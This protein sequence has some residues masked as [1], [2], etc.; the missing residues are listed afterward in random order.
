MT[1]AVSYVIVFALSLWAASYFAQPPAPLSAEVER[2]VFSATR[3]MLDVETIAVRPHP[4]GSPDILRVRSYI[5]ARLTGLN[6]DVAPDAGQK[7]TY[8]PTRV[9]Q[10]AIVANVHNV[11]ATLKGTSPDLPAILLMSHY[12]T[13]ANSP[14]APDD[15]A[16]V[17]A[18]LEIASNL[19]A[20][21][22]LKRDVIFL[23]TEGEE[24]GLLGARAFFNQNP[25]ARRVGLVINLESRGG[26]GRAFMFETSDKAGG[27]I[28]AYGKAVRDPAANSLSAFIYRVMPNGTDL[29]MAF[30]ANIPGLNFAF[31]G[32]EFAYHTSSAT[33]AN[34]NSG[35]VQH[36]GDQVLALTAAL[37]NADDLRASEPDLVY[38]DVFGHG[39][40]S[41]S[42]ATGWALIALLAVI[43]GFATWKA[44]ADRLV[45]G[46]SIAIGAGFFLLLV[47]VEGVVFF[48]AGRGLV[49]AFDIQAKYTMIARY[50]F[51]LGGCILLALAIAWGLALAL[52][53]VLTLWG[54][55]LGGLILLFVIALGLQIAAPATTLFFVWPLIPASLAAALIIALA[56]GEPDTG[57]A[58]VI[59]VP[60]SFLSM[61]QIASF[62]SAAFLGLGG[63]LPAILV[64]PTL[65]AA[66]ALYPA[67]EAFV[68]LPRSSILA[69]ALVLVAFVSLGWAKF[70]PA[71]AAHPRLTQAFYLAGP[72]ADQYARVSMLK[73]LDAWSEAALTADGGKPEWST[74]TPGYVLPAWRAEA[75][76]AAVPRP[77]L[78]G[79]AMNLISGKRVTLKIIPAGSPRELRFIMQSDVAVTDLAIDG[80]PLGLTPEPGEWS[81]FLFAAPTAEGTMLTFT[82]KAKGSAKLRVFEISD[83]WPEGVAVPLKPAGYTPF[84]T[85][86][87]TYAASALDFVW[88]APK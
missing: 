68:R 38:G 8:V 37:A 73:S 43:I 87:T 1:R 60:L 45:G 21:G 29:T 3:A 4:I 10:T 9:A 28:T 65:V 58:L 31:I 41:Y 18:M 83:G 19:K 17:A 79:D 16:G 50:D 54:T 12:D 57:T 69:A 86:D 52:R 44:R 63:F 81:Q 34:L 51:F 67:L 46:R 30:D 39:F 7:I 78:S 25:M 55:W 77:V 20:A 6:L 88:E 59:A 49:G 22:P 11:I 72:A 76:A 61:V 75:K 84:F 85:S 14:G 26:G 62:G 56:K 27:L 70:G 32:D 71:D 53:N 35:S 36:M 23:F 5:A 40:V 74:L 47:F 48:L 13:V 33:P 66:V 15:T 24:S 80:I 2:G 82:A 42:F 64:L